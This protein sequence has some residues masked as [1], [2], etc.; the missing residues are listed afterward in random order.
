MY[1]LI[2]TSIYC[3]LTGPLVALYALI[4][5]PRARA[6]ACA[7]MRSGLELSGED[8]R[9]LKTHRPSRRGRGAGGLYRRPP[10]SGFF[11][12]LHQHNPTNTDSSAFTIQHAH[13]KAPGTRFMLALLN[14]QT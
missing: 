14:K 7:K 2:L 13:P 12:S 11:L 10:V 8:E 1:P 6:R 9:E 3:A 5:L 4:H